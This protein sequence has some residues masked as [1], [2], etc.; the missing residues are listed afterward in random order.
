MSGIFGETLVFSQEKGPEVELVVYGDEFYARYETKEGYP[1]VYD[2]ALGLFCYALL[3]EGR[4]VSSKVPLTA[5]PPPGS[6]KHARESEAVRQ[7]K[8]SQ[9]LSSRHRP[10]SGG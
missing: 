9:K 7:A 10:D 8:I 1:V 4:F 2:S 5:D 3:S 6:E